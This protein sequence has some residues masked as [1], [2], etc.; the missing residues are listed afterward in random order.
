MPRRCPHLAIVCQRHAIKDSVGCSALCAL[1]M[2][3]EMICCLIVRF[4]RHGFVSPYALLPLALDNNPLGRAFPR[5]GLPFLGA[6]EFLA[7]QAEEP[8]RL[9]HNGR[10][11]AT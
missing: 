8:H 3:E 9:C 7:H 2:R 1:T 4:V 5:E 10:P 11:E 6:Q